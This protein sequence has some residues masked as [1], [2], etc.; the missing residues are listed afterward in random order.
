MLTWLPQNVSTFG[1]DIDHL[2][3]VLYYILALWFVA[4]EVLILYFVVRYHRSRHAKPTYVRGDTAAQAAWVLVPALIVLMLDLGID[5]MGGSA[6][7]KVKIDFPPAEN[8]VRLTAKQFN[9]EFTYPGPD[10]KFGTADDQT[11]ENELHVPV[12]R[13]VGMEIT[14]KDVIHSFFIPDLRLKQDVMP[15]RTIKVWFDA[16]KAG[17]YEIACAELC[18]FG[19]YSM[20]GVLTVHNADDYA[21]WVQSRWA[22]AKGAK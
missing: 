11:L 8:S 5:K 22:A 4:V 14:S 13:V 15:G 9:W 16:T 7:R 19:H 1:G 17:T 18:G 12:G 20:H 3:R 10:G 2:F 21:H 6:W